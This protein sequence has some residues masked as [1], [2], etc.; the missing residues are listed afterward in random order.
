MLAVRAQ[1]H[2]VDPDLGSSVRRVLPA[3]SRRVR[4]S[5][6]RMER[7]LPPSRVQSSPRR[8]ACG[9]V[10][11]SGGECAACRA[12]RLQSR[13]QGSQAVPSVVGEVLRQPGKPLES[14][15]RREL[16]TRFG[17]DLGYVRV[18]TDARAAAS[19]TAIGARAYAVGSDIAFAAGEYSPGTS[20]GR[21]LIAHEVIHT[22]Q[23]GGQRASRARR[24]GAANARAEREADRLASGAP[25]YRSVAGRVS[26]GTVQR[27][28]ITPLAPGGGFGGLM[29]RDRQQAF[30]PRGSGTVTPYQVCAR[31][32]QIPGAGLIANHAYVEAPP[33]RYAVI[34]PLCPASKLDNPVTGTTAQK[35]DNSPDPCGKRPSCVPCRPAPGVTDVGACLRSAF[36]A[37]QALSLYKLLGPNSNTFAGT[38]ARACCANM[39]P[40]P[41]ALGI[42]PGWNDAP[43]PARAGGTPCPPGPSC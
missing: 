22:I 39:A 41:D 20:T 26:P 10:V 34:G 4:E 37:Y 24:V 35:W 1:A 25:R 13:Q 31:A 40:K 7:G 28:L 15:A 19:A 6:A 32:L 30:A 27:Q 9:G 2:S 3:G 18:H 42:C 11:G 38:L 23:Q 36:S 8:C 29:E 16:Q 12:K 17:H 33:H 5:N 14:G 43:A 21:R